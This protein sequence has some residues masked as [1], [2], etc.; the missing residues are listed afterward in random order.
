MPL[1][2]RLSVLT[3]TRNRSRFSSEIGC[4][5]TDSAAPVWTLLLGHISSGMRRSRTYAARRPSSTS[6]GS[7]P[8]AV[9]TSSAY[10][11]SPTRD[12]VDDPHA[13]AEPVG[14]APL[15]R[16]PDAR[17]AERLTGVDGE[18]GVLAPEVLERVEVA[19]GREAGLGAGD[20]E[21]G[22]ALV[23]V[24]HD[25]PGDLG[26]LGGV[27][28]RGEQCRDADPVT[29][30]RRDPLTVPEAGVDRLDD[31]LE[32]QALDQV[33]LGGVADLGVDHPVGGEV[34]HALAGHPVQ[35]RLGLHHRQGLVE[36]LA[37]SAPRSRSRRCRGTTCRGTRRRSPE[38][39]A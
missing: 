37:G 30:L 7:A 11:A 35:P 10:G 28:H 1:I 21:A 20:V 27:P 31:L 26:A 4:S 5:A 17:Q 14:A 8:A 39:L 33:L 15:D 3:V 19:G 24:V 2:S 25:Q 29:G 13:V 18:V 9:A 23:A 12:V 6:S 38:A 22:H 34:L 36:R 32:G 16:L